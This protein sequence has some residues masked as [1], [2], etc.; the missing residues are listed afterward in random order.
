MKRDKMLMKAC[1]LVLCLVCSIFSCLIATGC[2]QKDKKVSDSYSEK[3]SEPP[4]D[5][6]IRDIA[7]VDSLITHMTLEERIGQCIFPSIETKT[8][9]ST[10]LTYKRYIEDYHVGGIV[11]MK[12]NL[13]SAEKLAE[14][15]ANS[16]VPLFVAIDA[17]WG[18]G[19]R[20]EDAPVYPRNGNINPESEDTELFDYGR[21]IGLQCKEVGINMVLGPVIDISAEHIGVIG[22]RSFGDNPE[23]VSEFGV[24]YAKGLESGGVVSVAKHFPGHGRAFNDS[25]DQVARLNRDINEL[26]SI[27]LRPF[28][29]YI[30]LGLTGIMAG[31]IEAK[32]LDPDGVPA[33]VSMDMLTALLREEM[34]FNGLIL[35]DAFD[36]G[37]VKGFSAVEALKAGADIILC[38]QNIRETYNEILESVKRGDLSPAVINDRCRRILFIKSL[39]LKI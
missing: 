20:L 12:G 14:I 2:T 34:G 36:M 23:R 30:N 39:I 37:G 19:M 17:E 27:D 22:K 15:G 10:I 29:E 3:I 7:M 28:R 9:P 5:S 32:A 26:D 8:D 16:K 35:T 6:T 31:H 11:L 24:A 21:E 33:S 18:L 4:K 13:E 38:P 25:H 1:Y